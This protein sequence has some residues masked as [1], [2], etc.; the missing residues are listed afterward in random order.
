[1]ATLSRMALGVSYQDLPEQ[2]ILR[3]KYCLLDTIAVTIGGSAMEGIPAVVELVKSKEGR[4]ESV[5]P[6]YGGKVPA[7]EA[8]LAIGPMA[9]AMDCGDL[10]EEAGHVSEYIVP[11][12]LAA[13]GLRNKVS[14][15]EFLTAMVVGQETL[16]RVGIAYKLISEAVQKGDSGGHYIFGAVAAAGK[17]LGLNQQELENAQGIAR[18]MTQPSTMAIYSPASL[19]VRVHHGL[20]SQAA[21]NACLLAKKGITGPRQQVLM[22]SHGYLNSVAWQ[23]EPEALTR[24]L[25][26]QWEM[27]N[28][29][30]KGYSA[31]YF[32]HTSI[33]GILDQM[34]TH[35]FEA[36]DI[37]SIQINVSPPAW[38]SICEPKENKW[39]PQT[40]AEC[41]FSLPFVVSSAA[42]DHN[43]FLQSYTPASMARKNVRELMTR[44]NATEDPT[45]ADW[46]ARVTTKIRDGRIISKEYKQVKGHPLKPFTERDFL[47]KFGLCVPHS[48]HPLE[49]R[50]VDSLITDILNLEKVDDV[51][52]AVLLP[53]TPADG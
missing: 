20:V 12:L 2:V 33:D 11:T 26:E 3:A 42:I 50:V 37:E 18:T 15:E 25:G 8:A 46:A 35:G 44:V 38:R 6:F 22:G 27:E 43:V 31:C 48:A 16:V 4:R 5:I 29:M 19:M 40:E 17:L 14:G 47:D 49:G 28:I 10:H 24:G 7:T 13:A 23:T 41:Q 39:N 52:E 53:L 32:A 45:L 9:R 30:T 1:M 21:I 36:G 34:A 51:V